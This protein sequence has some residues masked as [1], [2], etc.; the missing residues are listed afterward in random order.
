MDN[1]IDGKKILLGVCGSIAAY[2]SVYLVRL[3]IKSGAQIKVIMTNDAK[4]FITPLTLSTL[5][6]NPV[7]SQF[8]NAST[9]EWIN[10]VDL[11]K[12]ADMMII[13][14]AS[15]NTI[16]KMANGICDNLLMATYLS[17]SSPVFIAPAMD[18][19]MYK[20]AS[21]I[22]NLQKIQTYGN[23]I[24]AAKYGELA[25]GLV[26]EGR[27]AEPEEIFQNLSDF[28]LHKNRLSGK[29]ILISAGPTY[30]NIDPVRFIG[31]HSSGKMGFSIA[32]QAVKYGANVI[33]VSGPTTLHTHSPQIKRIDVTSA[34]EMYNACTEQF[35]KADIT[36]M[37][38]AVSDFAPKI[39]Y[40]KK[41]KKNIDILDKIELIPTKDILKELGLRKSKTQLLVGFALETNNEMANA[42]KKLES[43]NLDLLVLNSLQDKG[44]G[45]KHDTNK[46]SMIN[47]HNNV[48]N[49][50]LKPKTEVAKDILEQ[51][52]RL[53]ENEKN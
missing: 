45:F 5:S 46:V 2:K 50:E 28:F 42:R 26:G 48:I 52:L 39:R 21:T 16:A 18:L 43:K 7:Y 47:K 37:S 24:I 34:A 20:H 10:H 19:D 12:W 9:G 23:H 29:T 49:C 11:A 41:L 33:L 35:H 31:N 36:I 32:E 40:D 15:A 13:A 38:A 6:Q 22:N 8:S 17:C 1:A 53:I 14:P 3:L 44:A 27:M 25:S 4:E 51:I 30:E